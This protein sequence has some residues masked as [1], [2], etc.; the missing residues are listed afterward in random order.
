M[1][2]YV[3]FFNK[4]LKTIR[5][6]KIATGFEH[7]YL[8]HVVAVGTFADMLKRMLYPRSDQHRVAGGKLYLRVFYPMQDLSVGNKKTFEVRVVVRRFVLR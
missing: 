7:L 2:R 8:D 1:K 5:I 6:Q 4:T 3:F